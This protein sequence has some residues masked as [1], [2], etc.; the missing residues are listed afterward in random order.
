MRT[1]HV[2]LRVS[3]LDRAFGFYA[4]L[5]Y[6]VVGQVTESPIG[7]LVMLKLPADEYVTIELV[8]DSTMRVSGVGR[9][10][11]H[12]VVQVESMD[13][14]IADLVARG[15]DVDRATS[16]DGSTDFWTTMIEDPDGHRIELVQWPVG[17]PDGMTAADF[18]D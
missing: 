10:L 12:L 5:G 9:G 14:T 13:A 6:E 4:A 7:H 16:P 11:S 3:D 2:G 8:H 17:H 1:L 18:A 15:I